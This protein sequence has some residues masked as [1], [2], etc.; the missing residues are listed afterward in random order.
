M[1]SSLFVDRPR[2]A[3]VI[4]LITTIAGLL[5]LLTI[6]V[7][8][9]PDIVPPQVQ[10]TTFYPGANGG[11]VESTVA[12]PIEAQ[13]V[14]V[15]K[16][17]YMKS[18]SG[19]DGSYT[20]ICSFE[21]GTDPDINAV[22]VN[23]RVQIALAQ[24]PPEVQKQGVT[25]KN[26]SSALLGVISVYSPHNTHDALF[27][28]NYVTINMLDQIK[29]TPGVGDAS[30]WGPQDYA[31]R[32]WVK[33]DRLTGLNLTTGDVINAIQSQNLQAAVGRIGT[34]PISNDQQLQ[35]N[36]STKGRLTTIPEFENIV[37][38]T[39]SDGSILR[40][41]DVARLELG[42]ANL[43]RETRF[44]GSPAAAIAIYQAPGANAIE[45]L[46]A[47]RKLMTGLQDRFPED[48]A[49]K[50]TYDPTVFV[51]DTIH[52][53]KK[54]LIEAFVLV[55]L[56]VFLFL[57]SLRATLIPMFAVPVSLIG[58]F[59]V[60]KAIG[61]S[62]NT[63]SLL[64]VVL[65]IGIVVDD[66]IVV[67]EN[68][69]RVMEEH[70]DLTPAE[71]TKKAMAE[72]TA[73]IIGITLVLLSV[74]VPVAFIPGISG[75]LF[76]QFAVTVAVAMVLSAI[77]ALTLSPALCGVLLKRSHGRRGIM[78]RVMNAIDWTRD[79]YGDATAKLVRFSSIGLL[80]VVLSGVG[81]TALSKI[82]PTGFLP[83][84]D[85]GA[86]FVVAQLPGGAS[87]GRTAGVV[88]QAENYL[89][90]EEAIADYTSVVG[91]NFIDG[92][93][94]ASSAFIVVTLKPFEER[95]GAG[96]SAKEII[97]RLSQKFVQI[98]EGAV[99]GLAPPPIIGLGTGGGFTYVLQDLQAGDPKTLAQVLRGLVVAANQ[100]PTLSAVFSTFSATNPSIYLDID[101]DKAQVLGVPLDTIFQSLQASLGGYF[102]N[103]TNLFGRTWQVQVQAEAADRAS[104]DD[105][106]RINVRSA[107][108]QMIPLRSLVEVK[109]VVGPPALI[110][111]NNRRA[112][113]IQG[114]PSP[115]HSSGEALAAMEQVAAKTLPAGFAGEWTD[116]AFQEK[117]AEGK[118]AMI[119][120]FAILFA[121]LFLVALYESWTIPVPV[122]L[123]VTVG[124]LG[125][126]L[127]IVMGGLTL[128]LYAQIGMVVL[129]GLAAKNGILIVE[130]AK[131]K[132]EGGMALLRAA[133]LGA[134]DRFRPVMMT[135]FAFILGLYPLVVAVGASQ[136]ARRNVG[137]PVFGGML[138]ASFLGIFAIP[139]LYVFFQSI[140][141]KLRPGARPAE[142][143]KTPAA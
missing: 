19:D 79:R 81:V 35:L 131:E 70:P 111:Y 34:R 63:V 40:L 117:R 16:M 142:E 14:G 27:L 109:V 56:V 29:S 15:D 1:F 89:K 132:R 122:L 104:V 2:F 85:Q 71:A 33:T 94:Q 67:V 31:I 98:R 86:F 53:V 30:L 116:T 102:V 18:V 41:G 103:N 96:Q 8:Q 75:E 87:V 105:I 119:L 74:F 126:Y 13:V 5:A 50:V 110:R 62:A 82:T 100:D 68:V 76:R 48:L 112:V 118:T 57:G 128:D 133:E 90:E 22:N 25:V 114:G 23:N 26:K 72:I 46:G 65:A 120:G 135:S 80:F 130:F 121:Y 59:I 125:S 21:L 83:E 52:E 136:L 139:P 3:I 20:L 124:M 84:D 113:T 127:G 106:Y 66:A 44:N 11:V 32:A 108:G 92:Y 129:I 38:R 143:V 43:D 97:A 99:V 61:Y 47:I 60:L 88:A 77:N 55:V 73:P 93:S 17:I 91:L 134:R 78:G 4:A 36:I 95:Q 140:R 12:Q 115:G 9:Y 107:S 7:A 138:L 58:A 137:T 54:T 64:A 39:N 10:V 45:A 24:L 37:I 49:W 51:T 101:R 69:E 141:E 123:S 6:P 42:A 28:S